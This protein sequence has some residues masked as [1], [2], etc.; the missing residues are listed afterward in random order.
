MVLHRFSLMQIKDGRET[1]FIRE[2]GCAKGLFKDTV[3]KYA[4][5]LLNSHGGIIYF[6]IDPN[7]T[8]V[9]MKISRKEEDDFRL[10]IDH[11]IGSF[12]PFISGNLYRL[13]FIPLQVQN[14]VS[15]YKVIEL[16]VSVGE[17]GEIYEDGLS[18]VYIIDSSSLIGPLYPQE[19]KELIILKYKESMEGAEEANKYMTPHLAVARATAKSRKV[20]AENKLDSIVEEVG[21]DVPKKAGRNLVKYDGEYF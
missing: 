7:G 11:T 17:I 3:R 10:S 14:Q 2:T 8:I 12:Q 19:L 9:G 13:T 21:G 20:S 5:G 1:V 4:N 16:K 15:D 18:K 6:G